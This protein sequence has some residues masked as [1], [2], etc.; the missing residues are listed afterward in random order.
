MDHGNERN[1]GVAKAVR[2]AVVDPDKCVGCQC[3]MFACARKDEPGLAKACIGVCSVGGMERGFTVIV[4]R[5]CPDPP[6]ARVCPTEALVPRPGGGVRLAPER[7]IG[8]GHCR[9]ACLIGAVFWDDAAG[10]PMICCHCGICA[11]YCPYGVLAIEKRELA[12]DAAR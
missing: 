3:C 10:K 12:A 7:C 1:H 6:C 2:L 11:K 4:C 5:A 8:C 9:D